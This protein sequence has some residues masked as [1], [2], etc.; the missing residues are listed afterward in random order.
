MHRDSEPIRD[1]AHL[2]HIELLTPRPD[3]SLRFF[4]EV[5]GLGEVGREGRSVYLRGW[6]DHD[7]TTLKLTEAREAGLGHIGW[8][9]RSARR[10]SR[11]G[12]ERSRR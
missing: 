8:R 2:G 9:K 6:D 11:A 1:L 3:E 4:T 12:R 5:Y 7:L 10:R